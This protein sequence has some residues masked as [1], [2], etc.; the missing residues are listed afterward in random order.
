[1]TTR[2]LVDFAA[3]RRRPLV[4]LLRRGS[5]SGGELGLPGLEGVVFRFAR[6]RIRMISRGDHP[7]VRINNQPLDGQAMIENRTWIGVG[8]KL[9]TFLVSPSSAYEAAGAD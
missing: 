1:M 3:I 4:E 7:T 6:D 8:G 2:P 5:I 9:Y